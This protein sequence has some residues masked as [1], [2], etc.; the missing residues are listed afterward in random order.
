M[1]ILAGCDRLDLAC[2][3][4]LVD[5]AFPGRCIVIEEAGQEQRLA[6]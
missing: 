6:A 1:S 3:R 4:L 5:G 2:D